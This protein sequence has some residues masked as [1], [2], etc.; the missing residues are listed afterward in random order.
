MG[1]TQLARSMS[2][3]FERLV[4]V[5]GDEEPWDVEADDDAEAA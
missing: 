1:I 5:V 4:H 3:S 2:Q